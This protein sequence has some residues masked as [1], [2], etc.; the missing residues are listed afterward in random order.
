VV[1]PPPGALPFQHDDTYHG[2]T[3]VAASSVRTYAEALMALLDIFAELEAAVADGIVERY[4]VGGAVG[5]T[6]YIEPAAT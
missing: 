6:F 5:P 4:A 2:S 3:A 1:A